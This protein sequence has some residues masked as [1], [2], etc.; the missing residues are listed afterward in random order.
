MS[1]SPSPSK[2]AT[3]WISKS[4]PRVSEPVAAFSSGVAPSRV[5]TETPPWFEVSS[6]SCLPSPLKSPVLWT[7]QTSLLERSGSVEKESVVSPPLAAAVT[8]RNSP[9]MVKLASASPSP[10]ESI[11][12][13]VIPLAT[14]S[15]TLLELI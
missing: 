4:P 2:S 13:V 14:V 8:E 6:R 3:V 5:Q 11:A 1:S 12:T 7:D 9:R 10:L 15:L